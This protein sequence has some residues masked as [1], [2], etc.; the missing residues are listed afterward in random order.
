MP[1]KKR[2]INIDDQ[3]ADWLHLPA[4]RISQPMT[5][6]PGHPDQ[7]VHA[8]GR[9]VADALLAGQRVSVPPA[10][11]GAALAAIQDSDAA[12]ADLTLMHVEGTDL[13]DSGGLGIARADMPQIPSANREMFVSQMRD[14]G[15]GVTEESVSPMSLKPTQR[16][17]NA[18]NTAQM[19]SSIRDGSFPSDAKPLFVSSDGYVLDGHHRWAAAASVEMSTGSSPIRVTRVDLP[20]RD[21][22]RV[23][24]DFNTAQGIAARG[25]GDVG[26]G[27]RKM[28]ERWFGTVVKHPGHPDQKVHAGGRGGLGGGAAD[29]SAYDPSRRGSLRQRRA[30]QRAQRREQMERTPRAEPG[31]PDNAP[32]EVRRISDD[33]SDRDDYSRFVDSCDTGGGCEDIA[34]AVE[35]EYGIRQVHGAYTTPSGEREYHSWNQTDNGVVVDAGQS[36]FAD[37][38]TDGKKGGAE[39]LVF[40]AGAPQYEMYGYGPGDADRVL[41]KGLTPFDTWFGPVIKHPGHPDQK[42]HGR[43]GPLGPGAS[44]ADRLAHAQET[45]MP[46]GWG[47]PDSLAADFTTIATQ[48]PARRGESEQRLYDGAYE[49]AK[50]QGMS[51][52]DA[53][54]YGQALT[55]RANLAWDQKVDYESLTPQ[56]KKATLDVVNEARAGKI[57][58]AAPPEAAVRI[59]EDGQF[60]SQFETE[61]SGGVLDPGLRSYTETT[62]LDVAPS[63]TSSSRPIYG[64]MRTPGAGEDGASGYG[65][66]RFE[67]SD[68][69]ATRTTMTVGDSLS[70]R[71]TPIGLRGSITAEQAS[72]SCYGRG[73]NGETQRA[74]GKV[75]ADGWQESEY[76]EAQITGGVRV[77]DITAIRVTGGG[78]ASW[79]DTRYGGTIS[80]LEQRAASLGIPITFETSKMVGE[81]MKAEIRGTRLARRGSSTLIY[82]G[83]WDD[84]EWGHLVDDDGTVYTTRPLLSLLVR[85]YWEPLTQ[86]IDGSDPFV[87]WFGPGASSDRIG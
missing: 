33:L 86:P 19:A 57:T 17:L 47:V 78:R 1:A 42:I 51:D 4:S 10:K 50:Q 40:S 21:L 70:T 61:T 46:V 72:A 67:I 27:F 59:L 32:D 68:D 14:S 66:V 34:Q 43:K 37:R 56:E 7:K 11:V 18:V 53:N 84:T 71:A 41:G 15:I 76:F 64:Y 6:H 38:N 44:A 52:V 81:M 24:S 28:L 16:E 65:D 30:E 20:I 3:D 77:S 39:V 54:I 63:M 2:L 60:K 48:Y 80:D 29:S 85:G 79:D 73:S 62:I 13:F 69:V 82:D 36:V 31:I 25:L 83:N 26:S 87:K 22:L 74:L 45:G 49:Y 9:A 5:K 75:G 58:I 55:R 23:A 12:T 8:G 35:S